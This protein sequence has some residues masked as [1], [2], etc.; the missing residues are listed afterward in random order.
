MTHG[1]FIFPSY[2]LTVAGMGG[3]LLWSW[4]AMR[5]AE[6]AAAALRTERRRTDR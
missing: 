4:L 1:E 6:R 5:R 2:V 3:V